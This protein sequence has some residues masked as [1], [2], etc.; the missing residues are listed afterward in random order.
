MDVTAKITDFIVKTGYEDIPEAVKVV[1]K[2]LILDTIGVAIAATEY[3]RD[4]TKILQ[5][6]V[7]E[8]GSVPESRILGIGLKTSAANAAF[9]NGVL[10]HVLDY[11][12]TWFI[13]TG[14]PSCAIVPAILAVGEKLK[15]SG[16]DVLKAYI[17]A[18]E[19]HGK[20]G[21][22]A[23]RLEAAFTGWHSVGTF[24][25]LASTV[26]CTKMYGMDTQK[27][28]MALGIGSSE[29]AGF[30]NQAGSM[31][32]SFHAGNSA[33]NGIVAAM[34]AKE[35][36][37]AHPNAIE[38]QKGFADKFLIQGNY[39][40]EKL[41]QNLGN[42]Y[43]ILQP[44]LF[45]KRF[46]SCYYNQWIL[47]ESTTLVEDHGL[48][49]EI[50]ESI[51]L[52]VPASGANLDFPDVKT[53]LPAKFSWQYSIAAPIAFGKVDMETYKDEKV[54][55]SKVHELMQMV[56]IVPNPD[57]TGEIP[58]PLSVKTQDGRVLSSKIKF[59][60]GHNQNHLTDEELSEK[61]RQCTQSVLTPEKIEHSIDMI[62]NLD[63]VKDVT[64]VVDL[65]IRSS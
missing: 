15:L 39:E 8:T 18:M 26:A 50:I 65:L 44:G 22:T 45:L 10:A 63:Q 11:D 24:G 59:P 6:F 12:D 58:Y 19:V 13:P 30:G 29:A 23:K 28:R 55:D 36:Y 60:R 40:P 25:T 16:K 52:R 20:I 37:T 53:G 38:V 32:K 17:L 4:V 41:A 48:T 64:E 9:A 3:S 1:A 49:P 34:L 21:I 43:C 7:N 62:L 57:Q 5:T 35:G 56:K 31:T 42:P 54:A 47:E 2:Q 61:Y 14:H 27:T 46:P 33:K 51:E